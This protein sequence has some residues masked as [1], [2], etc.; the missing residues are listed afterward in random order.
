MIKNQSIRP[1]DWLEKIVEQHKVRLFR[2]AHSMMG[3]WEDAED[4]LQDVLIKLLEKSP[5]FKSVEHEIAWLIRVTVNL[6]KDRLRSAWRTTSVPLLD[7]HSVE[8]G[9]QES[10]LETVLS[11]PPK[12]RTAI[13]FFYYEGYSTREIARMTGQTAGA[14][15]QQ[16]A[17]ARAMLKNYLER[18]ACI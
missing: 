4:V 13:H 9:E 2:I 3:Q 16:L 8:D 17:R 14:V 15:Q 12:Y 5:S 6:C 1:E 11:L 18:E 7:I 10:L